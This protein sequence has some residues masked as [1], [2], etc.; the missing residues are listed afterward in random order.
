MIG[1]SGR[2]QG[3]IIIEFL[4]IITQEL[5]QKWVF[6]KHILFLPHELIVWSSPECFVQYSVPYLWFWFSYQRHLRVL[7]CSFCIFWILFPTRYESQIEW[8]RNTSTWMVILLKILSLKSIFHFAPNIQIRDCMT[9]I[10]WRTYHI[11]LNQFSPLLIQ[12][13]SVAKC[14]KCYKWSTTSS[15][16]DVLNAKCVFD[17]VK[18]LMPVIHSANLRWQIR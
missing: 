9:Y 15:P 10:L 14:Y 8:K 11:Y 4:D 6:W 13:C 12:A 18:N 3:K 1:I 2:S 7:W 5:E 16:I 17:E